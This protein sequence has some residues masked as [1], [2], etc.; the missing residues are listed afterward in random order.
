MM[1]HDALRPV[2]LLDDLAR[3]RGDL[4][5]WIQNEVRRANEWLG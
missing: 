4:L 2:D 5:V 1:W 3:V